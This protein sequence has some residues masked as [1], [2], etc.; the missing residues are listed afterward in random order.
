MEPVTISTAAPEAQEAPAPG[1]LV[2]LHTAG[3]LR[4]AKAQIVHCWV[5]SNVLDFYVSMPR[6][7]CNSACPLQGSSR[8][9]F[10][11][12]I[13]FHPKDWATCYFI[14]S[15][16][17]FSLQLSPTLQCTA[18]RCAFVN[19]NAPY[20]PFQGSCGSTHDTMA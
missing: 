4:E 12:K 14:D 20:C 9:A 8:F 3:L 16:I 18:V 13:I 10:G 15:R 19:S 11:H 6:A 5:Y 2:P 17:C 7:L 1:I